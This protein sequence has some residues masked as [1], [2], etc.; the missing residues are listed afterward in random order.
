MSNTARITA[1]YKDGAVV[2]GQVVQSARAQVTVQTR[3]S[4]RVQST[5]AGTPGP[6]GATGPTGV[7]GATGPTGATGTTGN[8]G[9]TG[10]TGPV[11]ATGVT[12]ATGP[13]G[14]TGPTGPTGVTGNTGATGATG[15][16][17]LTGATGPT[18][19]TGATGPTGTTGNTGATGPTG[20]TG[21]TG[22]TGPTGATGAT[23]VAGGSTTFVGN[24]ALTTGY[25]EADQV[26][27]NGSSYSCIL[28]HTS[29]AT[30]EPGVG[31]NTATYWQLAAQKGATGA[32]GPTG[33]TGPTGPT[34]V[35]GAVGATGP[36]GPTGVTGSTGP[37]GVTGNTGAT[38]PTG[39]TGAT[40]PTGVTGATGPTGVTGATGPTGPFLAGEVTMF[41]GRTVPA[42]HLLCYGQAVSRATYANLFAAICESMGAVTITNATPAVLTNTAHG[43]NVGDAVYLTTTGGLPTGLTANTIYY[44]STG[45]A[46]NT[47]NLSTTRANAYAGTKIATSSAG[48]GTHTLRWCPYGLGDGSTTFNLPDFRG[49][50]PAGAD[51]MG[52]TA[53]SRLTLADALGSYGN[54]G[55]SGGEQRHTMQ[56][57]ELATHSHTAGNAYN[58]STNVGTGGTSSNH[59]SLTNFGNQNLSLANTGSSTP[60]NLISPTLVIN[61]IIAI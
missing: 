35:T 58:T 32:T 56:T 12:G 52:G 6:A 16:T 59:L 49:R 10:A 27:H 25:S 61:Y 57:A 1:Q 28:A 18:G 40:G 26:T 13:T 38:G 2:N 31:V 33:V 44:V 55:A 19:V 29:S 46:A 60:F 48:S 42:T 30:D 22:A 43:L 9:P 8:T 36:T 34:G 14:I 23:G 5:I 51:A 15:V 7:T 53:A 37:T 47:F 3:E 20:P 17:G 11:G 21:V 4:I 45:T 54:I 41:T 50:T 24:W 39:V